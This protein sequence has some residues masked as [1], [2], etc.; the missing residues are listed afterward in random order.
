MSE[1]K[2]DWSIKMFSLEGTCFSMRGT[3]LGLLHFYPFVLYPWDTSVH[4]FPELFN[5]THGK[6]ETALE[7]DFLC[8]LNHAENSGVWVW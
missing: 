8:F 4:C 5:V 6:R 2:S 7:L 1:F 3:L